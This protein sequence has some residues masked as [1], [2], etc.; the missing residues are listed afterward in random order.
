VLYSIQYIRNR[1]NRRQLF[2]A[3]SDAAAWE[4]I[5]AYAEKNELIYELLHIEK[6]PHGIWLNVRFYPAEEKKRDR[7]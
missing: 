6:H 7:P 2:Y 1:T 5:K 4:Q 3:E